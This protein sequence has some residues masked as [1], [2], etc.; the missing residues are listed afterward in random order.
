MINK[1][2]LNFYVLA[3][4]NVQPGTNTPSADVSRAYIGLGMQPPNTSQQT[5]AN[6]AL[7][8]RQPVHNQTGTREERFFIS[9]E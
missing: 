7:G 1:H 5:Q 6:Q 8:I 3:P 4:L 9:N 2:F